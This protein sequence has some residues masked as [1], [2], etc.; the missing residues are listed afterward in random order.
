[1][2]QATLEPGLRAQCCC[3]LPCRVGVNTWKKRERERDTYIYIYIYVYIYIHICVYIYIYTYVYV[4]GS[5][6]I[7]A[8][9]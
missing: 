5:M 8:N 9:M 3:G 7:Y 4:Y 2:Q 1:M 6:H